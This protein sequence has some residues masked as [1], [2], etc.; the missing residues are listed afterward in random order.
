MTDI[1]LPELP[2][3]YINE[4]I[5]AWTRQQV[6]DYARSAVEADRA[7]R[8]ALTPEQMAAIMKALND[9]IRGGSKAWGWIDVCRAVEVAHGIPARP[10]NASEGDAALRAS[11]P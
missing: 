10:S 8:V 2:E 6:K 1:T 4:S 7:A 9:S 11:Q 5:P 3:P